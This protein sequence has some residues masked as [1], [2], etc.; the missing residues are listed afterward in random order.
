MQGE[1]RA[2]GESCLIW[3][4]KLSLEYGLH[5]SA[6]PELSRVVPLAPQ[7]D[8]ANRGLSC[9]SDRRVKPGR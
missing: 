9:R 6:G 3:G 8:G 7:E 4:W 5:E 2:S 1:E